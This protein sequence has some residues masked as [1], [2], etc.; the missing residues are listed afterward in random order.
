MLENSPIYKALMKHK[1]NLPV[2]FHVP[3]HKM[4]QGFNPVGKMD[5]ASILKLDMTEITGLDDLHHAEGAILDAQQRAAQLYK[6]EQTFF[7][8]NGTT[9][10]NLA[11]ILTVCRPGDKIIV[12]RNVH[13]SVIH[14]IILAHAEPIYVEPEIIDSLG[15]AA[16]VE[17][18]ILAEALEQHPD[19]KAVFLMNPNY[20]GIGKD[21]SNMIELTHQYQIPIL[22]DEAHGAHFGLHSAFPS[23][24]LQQGADA[25]VQSTHKTLSAMTMGSMLHLKSKLLNVDRLRI[26]LSML[27]SS[28][29]SYPIMASLDL[30]VDWISKERDQLW[31]NI[32]KDIKG[33]YDQ[34]SIFN[35]IKL[36][37]KLPSE[38]YHDPLKIILQHESLSG[39]Q[40]QAMLE[41]EGVYL[42][43]AD[44]YN[45]L[46]IA[47]IGS[48]KQDFQKLLHGLKKIDHKKFSNMVIKTPSILEKKK[49]VFSSG[50]IA[51]GEV[52]YQDKKRL[53]IQDAVG[54]VSAEMVI[55][56]PP[57]IPMIQLGERI[58][59]EMIDYL[60]F[61]KEQGAKLTG[62]SDSSFQSILVITNEE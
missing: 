45:T 2:S 48:I 44:L 31:D 27:Q 22:V 10:G 9:V 14:G 7:L 60:T 51:L 6:S 28:S 34:A 12:Q 11:L 26:Y 16:G 25:V 54:E 15:I 47:S 29:P 46:A 43:L 4:G 20:Y 24:A 56:Y 61:L 5:F 8:V 32:L 38:Y 19:A 37:H 17:Y 42:E 53:P 33:F 35:N 18:S 36:K 23:S 21:L 52:L 1:E 49:G 62:I 55:P 59:R 13:K 30:T 57:G 3:G 50:S 40:L 41:Q 39:Y 58:T